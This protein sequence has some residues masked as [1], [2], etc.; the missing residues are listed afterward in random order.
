M[1]RSLRFFHE[2]PRTK[3]RFL[4]LWEIIELNGDVPASQVCFWI[5]LESISGLTQ[6]VMQPTRI[7]M[8]L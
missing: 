6:M 5:F 7:V 2:H 3:W 1:G 4:L 8:I